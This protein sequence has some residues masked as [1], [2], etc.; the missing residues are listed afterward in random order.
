MN[1]CRLIDEVS[2]YLHDRNNCH[3]TLLYVS[4]VLWGTLV[5]TLEIDDYE[6]I[7]NDILVD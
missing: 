5:K 6:I 3:I 4:L 7:A 2:I 1:R